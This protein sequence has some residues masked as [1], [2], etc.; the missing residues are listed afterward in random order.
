MV[1][2]GVGERPRQP[3]D[4]AGP[5]FD[6]LVAKLHV[7]TVRPGSVR[8]ASLI[9]RLEREVSPPVVS[10]V[11]PAGYGKTTLLAQWVE[12][13]SQAVAWVS[14][15]EQD[16][17][18]KVLLGYVARALDAVQ[19]V[20]QPVFDALASPASSVPGSVVP[21]LGNA[22][23][24]MTVPVLLILDDVHLLSNSE[25]RA[26]L[27][28]LAGHVPAG[29]R[30][31]LAG[32]DQP[33]VRVARLR[34][35]GKITEIGPAD[36]ALTREEAAALLRHAQVQVGQDDVSGL[37]QRT[38]GWAAGLYLAALSLRQGGSLP[39]AAA[40]FAGSDQF[41]SQYVESELLARIS[42]GE[43][44][45]LT[46]AAVLDRVSG[47]L[48][49]AVL[50]LPGSAA[51]LAA[52]A[53]SNMLLVPLDHRSE[54]Y[55]Y[56]H[57]FRDMLR[58]DLDRREPGLAPAV[59]RRAAAWHERSGLSEDAL[60]YSIAAQDVDTAARLVEQLWL[61]AYWAGRRDTLERWVRWLDQRDGIR[62]RPMIAVMAGFLFTV[63]GRPAE[64]E[65]W[66]VLIDHWQYEDPGWAGDP[67]TEAFAATLR[68]VQCR[69]GVEQMRADLDE[70]TRKY[71]AAGIVTPTPAAYR[72][73]ACILA[74]DPDHADAFLQDAVS[75]AGQADAQEIL[76]G[77]LYERSLLAMDRG[78]WSQAQALA[79]QARAAAGW[80]G[81]EEA[82]VWVAQARIA[83]HRADLPAARQALAHAQRL[84]SFLTVAMAPIAVQARIELIRVHL[85]LAD[86]A[87]ARTLMREIDELLRRRPHLG[88]LVGQAQE[89]RARL[90]TQGPSP[91]TAS[92]LTVAELRLLPMLSTHLSAP[93]IAA[94]LFLSLHTIKA[95]ARSIYRKLGTASRSQTVARARELGLLEG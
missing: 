18:P 35:E 77:S 83:V 15:D 75:V 34:A 45:F 40:S 81:V 50:D 60:E 56:H 47:P 26:A 24:A 68:A 84:R 91:V 67:A 69:H 95:Q 80:P 59:Q 73:I 21:R 43:R 46:R 3:G 82:I 33:P 25:C 55:R 31:V 23:A 10:V 41:V 38:E 54:W 36:L 22:F 19:P 71:A 4:E 85:A 7:P 20:G 70:A 89:L 1:D 78:D 9:E 49:D 74:G 79:D 87:G 64:A 13:T 76:V 30:L 53:G 27:S 32:R 72:G 16:N 62:R 12:R 94:E 92:S 6:V 88:I 51:T 66:T 8:R 39:D 86:I 28:V 65:R 14:V 37:Y 11:A 57:L 58:A 63:T 44:E 52:L 61:P 29:S 17:D 48:C 90:A 93:E 42:P 5:V 2:T